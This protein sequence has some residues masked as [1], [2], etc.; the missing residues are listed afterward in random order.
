MNKI[1][2]LIFIIFFAASCGQDYNSNSGDYSQ[3]A[4][5]DG[6]DASI[7][8]GT[9]LL[10]AYKI[11]QAKC[12]QCHSAWSVYKSSVQW[13]SSGLVTQGNTSGSLV[14]TRLKNNGGDMPQ[15]PIAELTTDEL[16]IVETWINGI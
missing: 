2:C 5:Q 10:A 14:W 1:I 13:T 7:A 11:F 3:Y 12:F 9:R 15:D 8:D 16:A 4:P 6:I